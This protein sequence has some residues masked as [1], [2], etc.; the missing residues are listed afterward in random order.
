MYSVRLH[1]FVISRR[2]VQV[3][4]LARTYIHPPSSSSI[5]PPSLPPSG[6][7]DHYNTAA[8]AATAVCK[9]RR[10]VKICSVSRSREGEEKGCA[11]HATTSPAA[12]TAGRRRGG[13]D[14]AAWLHVR[15]RPGRESRDS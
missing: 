1:S 14:Y 8:A 12:R 3:R 15:W 4:L 10:K 5:L 11:A 13:A 2:K 7:G 9:N 6:Q